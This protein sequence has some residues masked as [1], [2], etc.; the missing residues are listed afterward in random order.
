MPA[1]STKP[2][3]DLSAVPSRWSGVVRHIKPSY[4]Y[5]LWAT[6]VGWYGLNYALDRNYQVD[7]FQNAQ[8][9]VL[10]AKGGKWISYAPLRTLPNLLLCRV[11]NG[12][13][14]TIANLSVMRLLYF[15]LLLANL[16]L[17]ARVQPFVRGQW[18]RIGVLVG[19]TLLFPIWEHG[20]EIR[21]DN[22]LL[23]LQLLGFGFVLAAL[24]SSGWRR[25]AMLFLLGLSA[26]GMHYSTAKAIAYWPPHVCLGVVV[27][28]VHPRLARPRSIVAWLAA[29]A[30][31]FGL[32]AFLFWLL[33]VICGTESV[34]TV[35][36]G[37]NSGFV[38]A[39]LR[40]QTRFSPLPLL[41]EEVLKNPALVLA[42]VL[43]SSVAI[44]EFSLRSWRDYL[45]RLVACAYFAWSVCVLLINPTPFP[46]NMLHV[47][48]FAFIFAIL[49]L[50]HLA[51]NNRALLGVLAA[52]HALTFIRNAMTSEF[53]L[54]S[55]FHQCS[56][57]D[58]AEYITP[59]DEPVLDAV[60]MVTSRPPASKQWWIHWFN[61]GNYFA[62]RY[63]NYADIMREDK[64]PVV[65]TN[66]RWRWMRGDEHKVLE[67]M[68]VEPHH[69]F[70]VLGANLN[71][72]LNEFELARTGHYVIRAYGTKEALI[73][74]GEPV[75]DKD[76]LHLSAGHHA[77][78]TPVEAMLL[79]VLEGSE[80]FPPLIVPDASPPRLF[81]K[82]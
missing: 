17:I 73:I 56:Y 80:H 33:N 36:A 55:N 35:A 8:N 53:F 52:V 31:G 61:W 64:P 67:S 11:A 16:T 1:D 18:G 10:L 32:G 37:L 76:M 50:S 26:A 40:M 58:A 72:C 82:P 41:G 14:S 63:R 46:Y 51:R 78:S 57:I 66:F 34:T 21:P 49:A 23:L 68:Y 59:E 28:I 30:T 19:A 65:I 43:A 71:P 70:H 2:G 81:V 48:P 38:T 39:S 74:D 47:A 4:V 9:I 5:I 79:W 12:A 54:H 24:E 62:G 20:I 27:C 44:R 15:L 6:I 29:S 69:R 60:G 25:V 22:A 13:W 3:N 77:Y 7:E 42:G 75:H 45:P